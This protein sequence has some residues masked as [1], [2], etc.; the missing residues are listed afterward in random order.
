MPA[1]PADGAAPAA[2]PFIIL[3]RCLTPWMWVRVLGLIAAGFDAHVMQDQPLRTGDGTRGDAVIRDAHAAGRLHFVP[4]SDLE[5]AGFHD[6]NTKAV[7]KRITAWERGVYWAW[8]RCGG[9]AVSSADAKATAAPWWGQPV[10]F[11]ED[12]AQWTDAASL[13]A[14]CRAVD[15]EDAPSAQRRT[16][17]APGAA[18]PAILDGGDGRFGLVAERIADCRA[19]HPA[20]PGWGA[21]FH[22]FPAS[23]QLAAAFVPFCRLSPA[24]LRAVAAFA[25][26][27]RTLT[28]LEVLL[29]SLAREAGLTIRWFDGRQSA[30]AASAAAIPG[31]VAPSQSQAQLLPR[32]AALPVASRWRPD[33][34]DAEL[35]AALP[36]CPVHVPASPH[37]LLE[38]VSS[39]AEAGEAAAGP[40]PPPPPPPVPAPLPAPLP[41][42]NTLPA[43]PVVFH[44]VKRET[45]VW[46][47]WAAGRLHPQHLQRD[48]AAGAPGA[49]VAGGGPRRVPAPSASVHAPPAAM[50]GMLRAAGYSEDI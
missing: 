7:R 46:D 36:P 4:D 47:D 30:P 23:L 35:A 29:P 1:A 33:W 31:S 42:P 28:F 37:R 10:Y 9:C 11:A 20:W 25:A 21:G 18:V 24:L 19:D 40:R 2:V 6:I 22:F 50:L 16:A 48:A 38:A 39:K 14:L 13:A 32:R 5:A 43:H 41:A 3:T 49:A 26:R 27:H 15:A 45:C 17:G 34:T 44:P 12:D 8:Q